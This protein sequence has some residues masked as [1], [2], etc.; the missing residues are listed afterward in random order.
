MTFISLYR[1]RGVRWHR[2]SL[3]AVLR[4]QVKPIEGVTAADGVFAL[5]EVEV[6]ILG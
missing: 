4:R 1:D 2:A 3:R 5:V 6:T